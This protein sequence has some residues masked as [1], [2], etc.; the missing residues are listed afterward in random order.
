MNKLINIYRDSFENK[1]AF[2]LRFFKKLSVG[3]FACGT[4]EYAMIA[5]KNGANVEGYDFNSQS[6]EFAKKNAKKL[7]INNC[8][9]HTKEFFKIKKNMTL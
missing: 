1:L 2:P 7:K 8:R 4:G 5:A 3:D 6:I 9:F